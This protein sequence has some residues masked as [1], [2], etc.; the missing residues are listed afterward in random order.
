MNLIK[1]EEVTKKWFWPESIWPMLRQAVIKGKAHEAHT[2][3][4][5]DDCSEYH[6]V[7]VTGL[8]HM[9]LVP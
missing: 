9:E 3:L 6:A 4:A 8:K 7:K 1:F 2:A 5:V